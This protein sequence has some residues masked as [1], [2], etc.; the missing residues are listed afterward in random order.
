MNSLKYI[1]VILLSAVSMYGGAKTVAVKAKAVQ[2]VSYY[3]GD[4]N[5]NGEVDVV[6]VMMMV[7]V[8]LLGN[9][10]E[11]VNFEACDVSRD[12]ELNLVDEMQTIKIILGEIPDQLIEDDTPPKDDD[13]A[14]PD[15][16]VLIRSSRTS[17]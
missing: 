11:N 1:L 14:N 13:P 3:L 17:L 4:A 16:P 12:G 5:G 10:N 2:T 9:F 8:I 6:D 15:Y 7:D